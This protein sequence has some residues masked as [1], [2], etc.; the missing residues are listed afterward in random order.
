MSFPCG[1]PD[2]PKSFGQTCHRTQH[3]KACVFKKLYEQRKLCGLLESSRPSTLRAPQ[4]MRSIFEAQEENSNPGM[5][6]GC[7]RDAKVG[8]VQT[9]NLTPMTA[10]NKWSKQ[11]QAIVEENWGKRGGQ[12]VINLITDSSIVP[13]EPGQLTTIRQHQAV[14]RK[15]P[16][17]VQHIYF[18]VYSDL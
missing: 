10:S 3:Q 18:S 2:C 8:Q 1:A 14:A 6:Y 9:S 7:V 11:F 12:R 15:L 13:I 4:P 17:A 16:G 5:P